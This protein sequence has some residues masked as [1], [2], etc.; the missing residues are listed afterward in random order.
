MKRRGLG[1]GSPLSREGIRK[2]VAERSCCACRV[3]RRKDELV[4]FART[5]PGIVVLDVIGTLPGRGGYVCR[6]TVCLDLALDRGSLARTL[7]I[8]ISPD[9]SAA[10]RRQC[11]GYLGVENV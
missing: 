9:Q 11:V 5:A 3:R 10:L 6:S 7:K 8:A 2:A 1:E 4:R